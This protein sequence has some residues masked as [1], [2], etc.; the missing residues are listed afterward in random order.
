MATE[1]AAASELKVRM[2]GKSPAAI[3]SSIRVCLVLRV[4][5]QCDRWLCSDCADEQ[6]DWRGAGRVTVV[7][8]VGFGRSGAV[9]RLL[10]PS[11]RCCSRFRPQ[12]STLPILLSALAWQFVQQIKPSGCSSRAVHVLTEEGTQLRH[13]Y[14]DGI[15]YGIAFGKDEVFIP[16]FGHH[17]IAVYDYNGKHLSDLFD[18]FVGDQDS[19]VAYPCDAELN[20]ES[21]L[22]V[23][24]RDNTDPKVVVC[25]TK[26]AG[27][28]V[29]NIAV[30]S[31][32]E[33]LAIHPQSGEIFVAETTHHIQVRSILAP[34][35]LSVL[36]CVVVC[37]VVVCWFVL[38]ICC[39]RSSALKASSCV[40]SA[41]TATGQA[42]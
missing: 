5:A 3:Q 35:R 28:V 17:S 26:G 18:E 25:D 12:A 30:N 42:S 14:I 39:G 31:V 15:A 32:C 7:V 38:S 6:C 8:F 33:N 37:F 1:I 41:D 29:R 16:I 2:E 10:V 11:L 21:Q 40:S 34:F 27:T 36:L 19:P 22:L 23:I 24:S 4:R 13:F 20:R 9:W